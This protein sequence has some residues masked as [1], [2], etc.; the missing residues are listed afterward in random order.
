M[1]P[2][3]YWTNQAREDLLDIY[4]LI[5]LEQPAA[6]ERYFD[7]IEARAALLVSQPRMGVRRPD[8]RQAM[9]MLVE[10]PYLILYRTE[11]D[12]DDGPVEMIE[13]VRVVDGRRE[14]SH[15]F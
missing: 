3:L 1:A 5:G 10:A 14:L 2:R 13:I 4:V 12:T 7:R 15:I 6:A 11:P 9:R 8:I